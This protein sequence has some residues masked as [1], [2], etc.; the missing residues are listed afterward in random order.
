MTKSVTKSKSA[1]KKASPLGKI[2]ALALS[3]ITTPKKTKKNATSIAKA[4]LAREMAKNRDRSVNPK[5]AADP[6]HAHGH[7]RLSV[8]QS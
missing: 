6:A 4:L 8:R 7:R 5:T 2:K 3:K 1:K